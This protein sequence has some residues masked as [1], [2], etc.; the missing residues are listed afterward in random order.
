MVGL[1]RGRDG[2]QRYGVGGDFRET[3][4]IGEEHRSLKGLLGLPTVEG[5]EVSSFHIDLEP[6]HSILGQACLG[7]LLQ[8]Y[9]NFDVQTLEDHP[10]R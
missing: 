6:A 4:V 8:I 10:A 2:H 7:I 3:G 9:D 5:Q 1:H